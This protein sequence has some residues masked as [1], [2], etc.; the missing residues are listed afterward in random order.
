[1]VIG[2][3]WASFMMSGP[4]KPLQ[5]LKRKKKLLVVEAK[6]FITEELLVMTAKMSRWLINK[7]L[8]VKVTLFLR[9]VRRTTRAL[10]IILLIFIQ[11]IRSTTQRNKYNDDKN[12]V[13]HL[14]TSYHFFMLSQVL[15]QFE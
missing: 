14:I 4:Y 6:C 10:N 3:F 2:F 5:P 9:I 7:F 13:A 15:H 12:S 1:M 11:L 8:L